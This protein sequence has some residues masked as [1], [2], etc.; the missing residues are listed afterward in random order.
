MVNFPL[1]VSELLVEDTQPGPAAHVKAVEEVSDPLDA[2]GDELNVLPV[3]PVSLSL[4]LQPLPVSLS[5]SEG[6]FVTSVLS[7]VFKYQ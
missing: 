3:H 7:F 6:H 4:A 2:S 1:E 5:C